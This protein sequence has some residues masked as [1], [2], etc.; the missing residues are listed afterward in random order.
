SGGELLEVVVPVPGD[1]AA[2]QEHEH[3][4]EQHRLDDGVDQG[5]GG[6]DDEADVAPREGESVAD[7]AHHADPARRGGPRGGGG[8]GHAG[9]L[10]SASAAGR[11]VRERKTSS[12]LGSRSASS[13]APTV[14]SSRRRTSADSSTGSSTGVVSSPLSSSTPGRAPVSSV[15]MRAARGRSAG[16]VG[17]TWR[18]C[19]PTR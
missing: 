12:R 11:A 7:G 6:A 10:S 17:R 13:S 19:P 3:H 15:R 16:S 1:R 5:R 4:E 18:V 14:A 2:E 8:G 9:V